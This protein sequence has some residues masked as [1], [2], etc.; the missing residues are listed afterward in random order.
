MKGYQ[1]SSNGSFI[2]FVWYPYGINSLQY[3]GQINLNKIDKA[4]SEKALEQVKSDFELLTFA[5]HSGEWFEF[6][7]NSYNYG[8]TFVNPKYVYITETE[9]FGYE[10]NVLTGT[11]SEISFTDNTI[12]STDIH[13]R[14]RYYYYYFDTNNC[15]QYFRVY[16]DGNINNINHKF[17]FA[18]SDYNTENN[19]STSYGDGFYYESEYKAISNPNIT[20]N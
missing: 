7:S 3:I 20:I 10:E 6:V 17:H 13:N 14:G 8:A 11:Y 2:N 4:P 1:L 15:S 12:A 19:C 9:V 16:L 18:K 5:E